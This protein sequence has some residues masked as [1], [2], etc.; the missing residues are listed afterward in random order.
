M[1]CCTG[2][3]NVI[4]DN[5]PDDFHKS[6]YHTLFESHLTLNG[7]TVWGEVTN[8]KLLPLF[9]LQK[10]CLRILFGDKEAYL[11]K[12]KTSARVR[13]F[14]EQKL[15]VEFFKREHSKPLFTKHSVMNVRNLLIVYHCFNEIFKY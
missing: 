6:L 14:E 7:I 8:N 5:I 4:K 2:I 12:F 15:G 1:S 11:D 10:K 13:L 3:L 9:R